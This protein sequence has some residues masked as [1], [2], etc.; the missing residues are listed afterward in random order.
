M[1]EVERSVEIRTPESIAFSYELAGLGSRFLA[2]VV[3]LMIQLGALLAVVAAFSLA[4]SAVSKVLSTYHF[5]ARPAQ[6]LFNAAGIVAL[7]FLF[8]GY[9]IFFEA[10]WNGLTPGK[11]ALGLR[12]MRDEGY[13]IDFMSSL[14][15]NLVRS[16]EFGLG[17]Y[18]LSAVIALLSQENKRLGDFAAGTIVVRDR[19]SNQLPLQQAAPRANDVGDAAAQLSAQQ[20]ALAKRYLSRRDELTA[21]RRRV[22]AAEI[23]VDFRRCVG[24]PWAAFDDETL[25]ERVAEISDS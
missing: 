20:R 5:S 1:L 2:V 11:R 8:F 17:F 9:F 6:S 25:I 12:V 10:F 24:L 22:L 18:A 14:I 21:V 16:L 23:A 7:F 4:A 13:P 15:R 19:A 3:D